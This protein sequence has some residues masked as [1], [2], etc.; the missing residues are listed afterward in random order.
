MDNV[1][2]P[3]IALLVGTVAFFALWMTMLKPSSKGSGSQSSNQY[4]SAIAKAKAAVGTSAAASVAHG[5]TVGASTPPGGGTTP[6][7][8]KPAASSSPATQTTA[9]TGAISATSKPASAVKSTT[10][11]SALAAKHRYAAVTHA[12]ASH[13]VLALLFYN[14]GGADDRAVKQELASVPTHGH[15]VLKLAVPL[16]ELTHY[17]VVTNQVPVNQ[18]PTLVLI[19][20]RGHAMTIVGFTDRFEIEQRVGDALTVK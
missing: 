5:G 7:A 12:L 8:A 20:P 3:M 1:S 14:P 15:K 13:R 10:S 18:S 9:Q 16:N 6:T 11:T 19:D 17:T 4:Q 2:R